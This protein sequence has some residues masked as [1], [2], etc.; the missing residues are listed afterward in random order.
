MYLF[1]AY[2]GLNAVSSYYLLSRVGANNMAPT[3][4]ANLEKN[5]MPS[6]RFDPGPRPL[7]RHP[8]TILVTDFTNPDKFI[9]VLLN[10]NPLLLSRDKAS[11]TALS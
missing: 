5:H 7:F 4:F 10:L 3:L 11:N 1:K 8:V 6:P 2:I 9:F